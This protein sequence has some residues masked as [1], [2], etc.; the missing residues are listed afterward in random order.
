MEII[1][2]EKN[3]RAIYLND[4]DNTSKSEYEI[5]NNFIPTEDDYFI[6]MAVK[7]LD[8]ERNLPDNFAYYEINN[9]YNI[10]P[11]QMNN[12][13]FRDNEEMKLNIKMSRN[14]LFSENVITQLKSFSKLED[15]WDSYGASKISWLTI[16]NAIEFFTRV[17]DRYPDSPIPF[18]SPCA[19]GRIHVEWQKFSKELHHLISKD[20][21]NYFIYRIINR[22]EGVSKEYYDKAIGID[23]MLK[24]FSI[25]DSY[26]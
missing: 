11:I 3:T 15:N 24:I 18:V 4:I 9:S 16:A 2:N 20:N 22:K 17:V 7:L 14:K 6:S 10:N 21:S 23:G 25:W 1:E 13:E 26:E 19:D 12:I 5:L 8:S